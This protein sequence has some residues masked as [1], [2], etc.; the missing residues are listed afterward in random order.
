[1]TAFVDVKF[2]GLRV[3]HK[4]KL[5][6]VD[7]AAFLEHEAPLPVG[8]LLSIVEEGKE[9][10]SARVARV[11][12]HEAGAGPAGM[13]LV[14]DA[15]AVIVD[16]PPPPAE[17]SSADVSTDASDDGAADRSSDGTVEAAVT[18]GNG[19][20]KKSKKNKKRR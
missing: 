1:M 14:W 20:G 17:T 9:P 18:N 8:S 7:S 11:V 3:A 19:S 4:A 16:A 5:T 6:E 2:R 13:R 15:D 10:R 12:E